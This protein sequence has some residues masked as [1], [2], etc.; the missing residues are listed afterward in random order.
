MTY[1]L[2]AW[3]DGNITYLPFAYRPDDIVLVVRVSKG[4]F[5]C[6][7]KELLTGMDCIVKIQG[8]GS[9]PGPAGASPG[10]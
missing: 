2:F 9:N 4:R 1:S 5:F 7:Q 3:D 10:K 6:H 8:M